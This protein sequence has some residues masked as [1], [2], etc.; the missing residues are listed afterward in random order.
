M[1]NGE[2]SLG[3]DVVVDGEAA[4]GDADSIGG[5]MAATV[6]S[7]DNRRGWELHG[8]AVC[9]LGSVCHHFRGAGDWLG[10]GEGMVVVVNDNVGVIDGSDGV[11]DGGCPGVINDDTAGI[12]GRDGYP[13]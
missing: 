12:G 4:V 11:V 3:V 1:A 5:D 10:A 7:G 2:T 8:D 9:Q 13:A 6:G